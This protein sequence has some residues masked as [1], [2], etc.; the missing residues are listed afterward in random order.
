MKINAKYLRRNVIFVFSE[1]LFSGS[2]ISEKS[3]MSLMRM[4]DRESARYTKG[5]VEIV[6]RMTR[7]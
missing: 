6:T 5:K 4:E 3:L 7:K 2:A 1:R